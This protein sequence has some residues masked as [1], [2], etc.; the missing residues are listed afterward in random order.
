MSPKAPMKISISI[1]VECEEHG[2]E[3]NFNAEHVIPYDP[4]GLPEE[5]VPVFMSQVLEEASDKTALIRKAMREYREANGEKGQANLEKAEE[6]PSRL[7]SLM[8]LH[9]TPVR[10]PYR[11][12][13]F[14]EAVR[15]AEQGSRKRREDMVAAMDLARE[16]GREVRSPA[17]ELLREKEARDRGY[18]SVESMDEDEAI[19]EIPN[20]APGETWQAIQDIKD[21]AFGEDVGVETGDESAAYTKYPFPDREDEDAS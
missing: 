6:M 13:P 21:A 9:G 19:R 4:E 10:P 2:I 11:P 3:T 12:S 20:L 14:A 7:E 16:Q 17:E 8:G 15:R 1:Y 5:F 18:D